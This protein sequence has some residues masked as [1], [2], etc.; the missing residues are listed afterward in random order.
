MNMQHDI[1]VADMQLGDEMRISPSE[2]RAT[3]SSGQ[4]SSAKG[5]KEG[6]PGTLI[7]TPELVSVS[8]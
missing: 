1:A 3:V 6:L 8:P 4:I 2:A 5:S 7:A